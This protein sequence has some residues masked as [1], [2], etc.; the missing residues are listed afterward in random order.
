MVNVNLELKFSFALKVEVG[1]PVGENCYFEA[2]QRKWKLGVNKC[3]WWVPR[4]HRSP[5]LM[6]LS[7]LMIWEVKNR[8]KPCRSLTCFSC[9]FLGDVSTYIWFAASLLYYNGLLFDI[10]QVITLILRWDAK[11]ITYAFWT[12]S[13][14]PCTPPHSCAQMERFFSN[15]FSTVTGG[16]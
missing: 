1:I 14:D 3:H 8:R 6:E 15:K 5:S 16:E 7:S 12:L 11:P 2:S 4:P 9:Y 13:V 10:F